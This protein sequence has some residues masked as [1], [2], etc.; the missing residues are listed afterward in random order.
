MQF[1]LS[2]TSSIFI[3]VLVSK[4]PIIKEKKPLLKFLMG[5]AEIS[6]GMNSY[7]YYQ[8]HFGLI[9]CEDSFNLKVK[10]VSGNLS[11]LS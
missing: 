9:K 5:A 11:F 6:I 2:I 1:T 4:F 7:D 3:N 10:S 8:L